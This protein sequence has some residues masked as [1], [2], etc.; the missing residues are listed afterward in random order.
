MKRT[1]GIFV[2]LLITATALAQ[3]AAKEMDGYN[4]QTLFEAR[5]MLCHQ[6]P[7]PDALSSGQ[8]QYVMKTMQKRMQRRGMVPLTGDEQAKILQYLSSKATAVP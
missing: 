3:E 1:A 6:L 5:C 7:E 4:G 8:W 2:L